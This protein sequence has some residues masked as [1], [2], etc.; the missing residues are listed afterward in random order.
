MLFSF[1]IVIVKHLRSSSIMQIND[2]LLLSYYSF[3]NIKDVFS[4][5]QSLWTISSLQRL[6]FYR[7]IYVIQ[8][9]ILST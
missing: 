4:N 7:I 3:I 5:D 9:K 1:C 2:R 6:L 8:D